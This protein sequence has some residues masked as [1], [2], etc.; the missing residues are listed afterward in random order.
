MP[1]RHPLLRLKR[2]VQF[3]LAV[4]EHLMAERVGRE[5]SVA[6]RVP[7]G[8]ITHVLRMIED[9]KRDGFL[10]HFACQHRP[11]PPCSPYGVARLPLTAQVLPANPCIIQLR[12]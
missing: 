2:E 10:A 4:T 9:G 12:Y 1:E 8:R 3:L 5:Q 7:I 11:A 6:A